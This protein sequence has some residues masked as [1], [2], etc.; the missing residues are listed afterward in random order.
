MMLGHEF[1]LT[2][3]QPDGLALPEPANHS[4]GGMGH[5][6]IQRG[7]E[8]GQ[9]ARHRRLY[10]CSQPQCPPRHFGHAGKTAVQLERIERLTAGDCNRSLEH[11]VLSVTVVVVIALQV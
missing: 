3:E 6:I 11:R 1:S 7:S 2:I 10:I 9:T 8:E 5:I 4:A